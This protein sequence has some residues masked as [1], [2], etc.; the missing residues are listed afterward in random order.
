[1]NDVRNHLRARHPPEF[2]Q[3]MTAKSRRHS[4]PGVHC[5][6]PLVHTMARALP[7]FR[8]KHHL[9]TQAPHVKWQIRQLIPGTPSHQPAGPTL[10]AARGELPG[11]HRRFQVGALP[12]AGRRIDARNGCLRSLRSPHYCAWRKS[13]G[14]ASSPAAAG[15]PPLSFFRCPAPSLFCSMSSHPFWCK[16]TYPFAGA[17]CLSRSTTPRLFESR[18]PSLFPSLFTSRCFPS[19]SAFHHPFNP[20]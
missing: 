19:D 15:A 10:L 9:A 17:L 20:N 18:Q 13:Q 3:P 11:C 7:L 5:S 6:N 16:G 1:M 2:G 12:L 8:R 14:S 4:L